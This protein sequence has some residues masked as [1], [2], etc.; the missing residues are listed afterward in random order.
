LG[1]PG[2]PVPSPRVPSD[3]AGYCVS[4]PTSISQT[5]R[6]VLTGL[7][8]YTGFA[9]VTANARVFIGP[10]QVRSNG[11]PDAFGIGL[12]VLVLGCQDRRKALPAYPT[13]ARDRLP[14]PS[15]AQLGTGHP[16][17][18]EATRGQGTG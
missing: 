14:A 10:E 17:G 1:L 16:A 4:V 3:P 13:K 2:Y 7:P 5:P 18:C 12:L 6:W 11:N 9:A 8:G 15:G